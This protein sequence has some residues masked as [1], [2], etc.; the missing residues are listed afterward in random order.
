[1]KAWPREEGDDN[2]HLLKRA[3]K[4]KHRLEQ[5]K[6]WGPGSRTGRPLQVDGGGCSGGTGHWTRS[7]GG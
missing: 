5:P 7:C 1:M 2:L 6:T 4:L 3:D